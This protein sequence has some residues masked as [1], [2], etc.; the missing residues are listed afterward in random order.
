MM[1]RAELAVHRN[2]TL[3]LRDVSAISMIHC[4]GD[5]ILFQKHYVLMTQM[6]LIL[7]PGLDG[8]GKFF[9]P[10]VEHYGR[11]HTQIIPLPE[12][13]PQDYTAL[14]EYVLQRLPG[15]KDYVLLGE[16]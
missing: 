9:E 13:G 15:N 4:Y 8:S 3:K 12:S 6:T 1:L 10:F 7:I 14:T 11:A 5:T 2:R 16:S